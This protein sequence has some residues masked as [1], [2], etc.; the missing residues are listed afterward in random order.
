MSEDARH[1]RPTNDIPTA[2]ILGIAAAA[3]LVPLNSTMI[4]V[5]LPAITDDFEVSTATAT[6]LITI[7]LVVMLVGQPIAGRITDAFGARRSVLVAL[8]G[9]AAFSFGA[10]IAP[11]FEVL[12]VARA[13]QAMCA[14]TLS[15]GAQS[16]LRSISSP[17]QQGRVFGILGS[18]LG[19]G[20]ALGPVVGGV[21]VQAFGWQAIFLVNV[22]IA[23]MALLTA[24]RS[25]VTTPPVDDRQATVDH[26][27]RILNRVFV[28]GF[29]AQALSTQAQ[30]ALLLLT[31]IVLDARGW[32][33]GPIGL[34]LSALTL[35]MIVMG[36]IGGRAGDE[37]GRR[38]PATIGLT[39]ASTAIVALLLGG[40]SIAPIVMVAALAVFGVG[41]GAT[42][43]NLMSAAL[44]SVPAA[45]AGAAAGIL[46][47]SRYVGSIGTSLL[48]A[49]FV[50]AD[51]N[52]TRVVLGISAIC[53]ILAILV[54]RGLPDGGPRS[55][56]GPSVAAERSR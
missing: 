9:L 31:P 13:L 34:V 14:A 54:S 47:M 11:S 27:E 5:A 43:P 55:A 30:Y 17:D 23:A 12:L 10:A 48:I 33:A 35:G 39:V 36:P 49:G 20:A 2:K 1:L 32:E 24:R 28:V 25:H 45:R 7:Y 16:L 3:G 6:T 38:L 4:A 8:V 18:V 21:L 50:T 29:S 46:S 40:P 44:G 53:M 51:A 19:T 15:P 26:E 22:P 52:G 41:L 37:R 42:T 56:S